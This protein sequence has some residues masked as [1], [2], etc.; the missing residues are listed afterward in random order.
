MNPRTFRA[1]L[2]PRPQGGIEV[3][4][5]FD[6]NE[7]W[8]DKDRHYVAGSIDGRSFRGVLA[9]GDDD[10]SLRLGPTW[11][12]DPRVGPGTDATVV[13]EP[14][15]PQLAGLSPD[16]RAALADEPEA[17]RFFEALATF[18]RNGYVSCIEEAKRPETRARRIADAVEALRTGQRER[19]S[20]SS[21]S[22][23][24]GT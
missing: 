21:V 6:P 3:R 23:R 13:I 15:G 18:Y 16:L 9:A 5:P 7:A 2:E 10:Y 19:A 11:C 17:R 12:R 24:T 22:G 14:E 4:L 20:T 1:V 8:G